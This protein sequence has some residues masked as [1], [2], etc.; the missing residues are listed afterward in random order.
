MVGIPPAASDFGD[1]TAGEGHGTATPSGKPWQRQSAA[2]GPRRWC[3]RVLQLF[4]CIYSNFTG[5]CMLLEARLSFASE[6]RL[7][8]AKKTTPFLFN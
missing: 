8:F 4:S 7:S 2:A 6:A 3:L 5:V 1:F